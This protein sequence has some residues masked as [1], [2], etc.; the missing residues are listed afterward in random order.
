MNIKFIA[1][2]ILVLLVILFIMMFQRRDEMFQEREK[3]PIVLGEYYAKAAEAEERR[4]A[5]GDLQPSPMPNIEYRRRNHSLIK[6]S[7]SLLDLKLR[8]LCRNFAESDARRRAKIRA[9]ISMNEFYTLITFSKRA[10]VFAR[11]EQN[12]N[13][14]IDGLTALAMIECERVDFR[15]ILTS[16][17]LLFHSASKIDEEPETLFREAALLSEKEVAELMTGFLNRTPEEQDIRL[18]WG[19]EEVETEDGIGYRWW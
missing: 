3:K 8:D 13:H 4:K 12:V 10:A 2:V 7:Q 17:A 18:S 11:R 19:Y 16:L 14:V 5:R 1:G 15:D 9:S 6:L